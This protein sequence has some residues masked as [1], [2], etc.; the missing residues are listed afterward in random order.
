MVLKSFVDH[1]FWMNDYKMTVGTMKGRD[2]LEEEKRIERGNP[3]SLDIKESEIHTHRFIKRIID[4]R[5][6]QKR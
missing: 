1:K 6:T 4:L 5:N 2:N 3:E